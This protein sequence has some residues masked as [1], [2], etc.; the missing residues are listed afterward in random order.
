MVDS[1][2]MPHAFSS[3]RSRRHFA[4]AANRPSVPKVIQ[5]ERRMLS[6]KPPR[7]TIGVELRG[8]AVVLTWARHVPGH[9][10]V[11]RWL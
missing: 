7:P 1:D 8:D 6:P 4:D 2:V 3:N 5:L 9:N 11:T 10:A